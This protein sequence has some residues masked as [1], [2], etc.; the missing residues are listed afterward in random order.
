MYI[1][2][3]LISILDLPTLQRL[4]HMC[5]LG[6]HLSSGRDD[7]RGMWIFLHPT[8]WNKLEL[9]CNS[10]PLPGK[11]SYDVDEKDNNKMAGACSIWHATKGPQVWGRMQG[12]CQGKMEG[13]HPK[14]SWLQSGIRLRLQ[15][16]QDTWIWAASCRH[17]KPWVW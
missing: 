1:N 14:C 16:T 5:G 15:C 12:L 9:F 7:P 8:T 11:G 2:S 6:H 13:N 3:T 10:S 17:R 4:P